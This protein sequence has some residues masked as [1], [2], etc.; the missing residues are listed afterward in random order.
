MTWATQS[1]IVKKT[2]PRAASRTAAERIARRHAERIYTGRETGTSW[3]FR[4]RPPGCFVAGTMRTL[5][6]TEHVC[7]IRGRLKRG[8]RGRG[9]C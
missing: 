8:A 3:R 7:L 1:V 4:Q 6:V 5:C 2:H 9:R